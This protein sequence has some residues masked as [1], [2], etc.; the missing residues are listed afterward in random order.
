MIFSGHLG[1][2]AMHQPLGLMGPSTTLHV[3]GPIPFF[4]GMKWMQS[5]QSFPSLG[6][7]WYFT[8]SL[9]TFACGSAL[10][11]VASAG[12]IAPAMNQPINDLREAP[13]GF[14]A[15]TV[16]PFCGPYALYR[17]RRLIIPGGVRV[18]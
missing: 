14:F 9:F 12:A 5:S 4:P 16:S 2:K 10:P 6:L 15:C 1:V 18:L 8:A 11:T 13:F 7:F 17:K 3:P